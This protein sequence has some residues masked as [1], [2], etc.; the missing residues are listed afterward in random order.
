MRRPKSPFNG[1]RYVLNTATGEIHDLDHETV[2][3]QI[4]KIKPEH[5]LS[6]AT[7]QQAEI[8]QR[9][10]SGLY[11]PRPDGCGHCIKSMNTR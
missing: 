6:Y 4:D 3:C 10:R 7:Y 2:M 8:G 9:V 11:G 1:N 5:V